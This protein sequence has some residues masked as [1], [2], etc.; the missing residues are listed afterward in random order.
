MLITLSYSR[1]KEPIDSSRKEYL[2]SLFVVDSKEEWLIDYWCNK[3]IKGLIT[4]P[5]SRHW[6]MHI[7]AIKMIQEKQMK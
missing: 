3:D 1:I 7:E 5:L 2:R 4:M 6:I